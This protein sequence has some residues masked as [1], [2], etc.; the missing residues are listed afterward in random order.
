MELAQAFDPLRSVRVA[1]T[2]FRRAPLTVFLGGLLPLV[3]QLA[4]QL[5]LQFVLP[6]PFLFGSAPRDVIAWR[7]LP[8]VF[9]AA[10][11]VGLA[12]GALS[13]WIDVGI[14]RAIELALRNGNEEVR[15][16]FRGAD[17][18]WTMVL[19]RVLTT[20]AYLLLILPT[21]LAMLVLLVVLNLQIPY[22]FKALALLALWAGSLAAVLYLYLGF[23]MVTA[24][25]AFEKCSATEAI[26]KSW[27][28]ARGKRLQLLWFQVFLC[29]LSIAGTLACFIGLLV[30]L[31]LMEVMRYEAY[32]AL[33]NGKQYPRWWVGGAQPAGTID[34]PA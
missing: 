24:I 29:L 15:T 9:L 6:L 28:L 8:I 31:P 20:L 1:G 7:A 5:P 21:V 4:L 11:A 27:S 16:I 33:A 10:L 34:P 30:A 22:V 18:F 14:G 25:I 26:A 23:S 17:R 3:L 32:L 2:L 13:C 19:A 12:C